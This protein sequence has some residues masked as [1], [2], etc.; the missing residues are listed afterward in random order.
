MTS[1]QRGAQSEA[2][3]KT[4]EEAA[5]CSW[6]AMEQGTNAQEQVVKAATASGRKKTHGPRRAFLDSRPKDWAGSFNSDSP[7]NL[8]LF[9]S[10]S[11]QNIHFFRSVTLDLWEALQVGQ[12]LRPHSIGDVPAFFTQWRLALVCSDCYNRILKTG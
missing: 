3:S 8:S 12:H 2:A 6:L 9:S 4:L 5:R 1:E 10:I 7:P 11:Y